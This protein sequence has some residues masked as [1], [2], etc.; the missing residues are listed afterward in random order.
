[1]TAGGHLEVPIPQGRQAP[2]RARDHVAE[3]LAVRGLNGEAKE[4]ALIIA[5]E[6][7]ANAVVH[8]CEPITLEVGVRDHALRIEVCDGDDHTAVVAPRPED[9][10]VMTGRGRVIVESLAQRWGVRSHPGGKSVWAEID[11]A[12]ASK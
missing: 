1:M 2:R 8:A 4:H 6:L 12:P 10:G 11:V 9:R 5:S 7:V 3:F